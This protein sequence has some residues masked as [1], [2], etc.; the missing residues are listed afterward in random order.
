MPNIPTKSERLRDLER[1]QIYPFQTL[2]IDD[3]ERSLV[4]KQFQ[5]LIKS[6]FIDE[7]KPSSE[8]HSMFKAF[9]RNFQSHMSQ[10]IMRQ[11][12]ANIYMQDCEMSTMYYPRDDQLFLAFYN[13]RLRQ[14]E[15]GNEEENYEGQREWRAAYRV[16]PDFENWI[17]YF[18]DEIVIKSS[19]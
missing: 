19:A 18:A 11:E 1:P 12:L 10:D 4:L 6:N 8:K 13:R 9:E 16:M 14:D 2:P 17:K 3:L 5:D 15:E 7:G